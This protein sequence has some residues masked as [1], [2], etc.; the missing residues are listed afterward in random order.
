MT[1]SIPRSILETNFNK[2]YN[3][4]KLMSVWRCGHSKLA[5]AIFLRNNTKERC[6]NLPLH[7]PLPP[8]QPAQ[9]PQQ[10]NYSSHSEATEFFQNYH[11]HHHQVTVIEEECALFT[12]GTT[13]FNIDVG[14][15]SQMKSRFGNL[16]PQV[17]NISHSSN[18]VI[19]L[20]SIIEKSS[21]H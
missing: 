1:L 8:P 15:Y 17:N 21:R 2:V 3:G 7:P 10:I 18:A 4:S 11:H 19:L 9:V 13:F 5:W 16:L 6:H 14:L 20:Q 12:P